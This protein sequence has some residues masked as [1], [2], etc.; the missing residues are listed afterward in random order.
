MATGDWVTAGEPQL[1]V[2]ETALHAPTV[3]AQ[4]ASALT[5]WFTGQVI[6]GSVTSFKVTVNEQSAVLP[7]P[8]SAV[9]VTVSTSL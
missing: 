8:S 7:F 6:T 4:E 3:P 1:S 2:A 5:V 9:S